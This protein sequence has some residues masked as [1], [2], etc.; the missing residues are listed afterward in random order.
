MTGPGTISPGEF[1][2]VVSQR[3]VS[4]TIVTASGETGPAGLLGLSA[5]HVCDDPPTM[6]VSVGASTSALSTILE[7]QH[8]AINYLPEGAERLA[9][10]FSGK[11]DLK[12]AERFESTSWT[13]LETGA[14]VL[15]IGLAAIDCRLEDVIEHHD[16]SIILGVVVAT[17]VHADRAPLVT[18]R[19]GY[20]GQA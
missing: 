18:F 15:D 7:A 9:D 16:T 14:P 12:R 20:L 5:T 6:L 2:G 17:K 4:A 8:F 13:T 19:G 10:I 3:A 11:T 1:W